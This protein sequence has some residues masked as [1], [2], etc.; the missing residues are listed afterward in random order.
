MAP[1]GTNE[2]NKNPLSPIRID[3]E[4]VRTN[5]QK[6]N[7]DD[8]NDVLFSEAPLEE[9]SG[10]AMEMRSILQGVGNLGSAVTGSVAGFA[11]TMNNKLQNLFKDK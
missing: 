2:S 3:S 5:P 8:W 9:T 1:S 7:D 4:S 10:N 11:G 6:S